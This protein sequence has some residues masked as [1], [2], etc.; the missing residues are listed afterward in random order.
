MVM[1]VGLVKVTCLDCGW[2]CTRNQRSDVLM[3]PKVCGKCGGKRLE[4]NMASV[5]NILQDVLFIN[6]LSKRILR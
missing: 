3:L 4:S 6:K 1:P 5:I 2:S